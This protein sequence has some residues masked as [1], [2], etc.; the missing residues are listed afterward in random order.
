MERTLIGEATTMTHMREVSALLAS[1][2]GSND[3]GVP[4]NSEMLRSLVHADGLVSTLRDADGT[5]LGAAVLGR[6]APGTAYSFIAAVRPGSEH[7]GLGVMLKQHQ[8]QWCLARDI[9]TMRWTFDPLVARNARFNLVKLGARV[10]RYEPGFYGVMGDQ[11]N[12]TD[13]ADRMVA[14]WTL[15]HPQPDRSQPDESQSDPSQPDRAAPEPPAGG[16]P[17]PDG[18]PAFAEHHGQRWVR[19]PRDIVALRRERPGEATAWR[20]FTRDRLGEALGAGFVAVGF[21]DSGWYH[22]TPEGETP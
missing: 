21:T 15:T 18:E 16:T 7:R 1:V 14:D 12:G 17:G 13:V 4:I 3:E 20:E 10:R 22:L 9:T 2:W 6:A 8:L 19:V 11:I 5:L